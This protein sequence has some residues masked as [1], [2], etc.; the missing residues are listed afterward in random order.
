MVNAFLLY[1]FYTWL[2][3]FGLDLFLMNVIHYG[4][5]LFIIFSLIRIISLIKVYEK[6]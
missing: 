4:F 3:G 1:L 6:N 2:T 5:F